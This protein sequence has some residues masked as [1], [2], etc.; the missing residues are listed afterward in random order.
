MV[1]YIYLGYSIAHANLV[2]GDRYYAV[3]E[4]CN[5]AGLCVTTNSDGVILDTSPPV[6]GL[7]LDGISGDD[8]EF[9]SQR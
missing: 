1:F 7:V 8:V 5:A 9:Q 4:A 6:L 3:V 2:P